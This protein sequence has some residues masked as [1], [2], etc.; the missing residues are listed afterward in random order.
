[1]GQ[2]Q[3]GRHLW[4]LI[5]SHA[6]ARSIHVIA[7][8]GVADALADE[9]RTAA[10]LAGS[11]GLDAGALGRILRLLASEGVFATEGD[12]FVHTEA[13]RLLRSDHEQSLRSLARMMGSPAV[14]QSFT[15]LGHAAAHGR[16]K[17]GWAAL[18]AHFS[19]HPEE[20]ALFNQA[21]VDKA[22]AVVPA[23]V[24]AFDFSRFGTIVDVGGGRGH[25]LSRILDQVPQAHGILFDLPHVV[26]DAS[27]LASPRL[28]LVAGD[29]FKDD[30][31]RADAYVLM[32]V[33]HDWGDE[34]ALRILAAI[35]RCAP[36]ESRVL[37]VESLV[38]H[39]PEP[40]RGK[41]MDV[42]MLAIT[43]G[44]ERTRAEYESL[45]ATAGFRLEAIT[46]TP[47]EYSIVEAAAV[48]AG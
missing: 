35:R 13:S 7:E 2:A 32:E 44:R 17:T 43:G 41:I 42:V 45:L 40:H 37:I 47:V 9:P 31:P 39:S 12:A 23:V 20:A 33:L 34:E 18:V 22:S 16:P 6:L 3:P 4:N 24:E 14:W 38:P 19:T 46:D 25:L 48:G 1:V 15:D 5:I 26:A 29:F 27:E 21:M 36:P 8:A 11:A 10:E 28:Q 30:L